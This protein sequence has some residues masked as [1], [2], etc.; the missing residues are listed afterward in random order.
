MKC[1]NCGNELPEG[2]LYC[3]K[4][5]KAVQMVPD[6]DEFSNDIIPSMV[7]RQEAKEFFSPTLQK[8]PDPGKEQEIKKKKKKPYSKIVTAATLVSICIC[9]LIVF[10]A[11]RYTMSY[12]YTFNRASDA[13]LS[14]DYESAIA[15]YLDAIVLYEGK[16][17]SELISS[18]LHIADSYKNLSKR[19]EAI[20][21][22]LKVLEVDSKNEEAFFEL[23]DMMVEDEDYDGLSSLLEKAVTS[24][25]KKKIE[26]AWAGEVIF[27]KD[28]GEYEDDIS[29]SL[30]S[31]K[32]YQIYYT[33]NGDDP[34][35]GGTLFEEPIRLSDGETVI[36]ARAVSQAG[37][38]GPLFS[39]TY[40]IVYKAPDLPVIVP[41][42]GN[43]S[44][45]IAV[46]IL[47]STKE[48]SIYYTWDGSRPDVNSL[49]Y[50]GPIQVPE[51]NNVLSVM[52]IDKHGLLS[53]IERANFVYIPVVPVSQ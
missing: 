13:Y 42:G 10:F 50:E 20:S 11:I 1:A 41:S 33:L 44:V 45:P 7:A 17:D 35:D 26:D 19:P 34:S 28:E 24:S 27:S 48:A 9:A 47:T 3:E 53:E 4:C 40:T 36:K 39:K 43:Y 52:V 29:I 25:Q 23:T 51:G 2:K 31:P 30:S 8:E 5:G 6:Y 12:E 14:G 37:V 18:Y 22:Y 46:E 38:K 32:G 49:R 15:L 21:Y 16:D